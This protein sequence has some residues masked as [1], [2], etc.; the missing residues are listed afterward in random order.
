LGIIGTALS[1]QIFYYLLHWWGAGRSATIAYVLPAVA[2]ILGIVFLDERM[3]INSLTGA[4]L[5]LLGV[6]LSNNSGLKIKSTT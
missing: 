6:I 4:G 1:Y 3:S 5:I 2:L